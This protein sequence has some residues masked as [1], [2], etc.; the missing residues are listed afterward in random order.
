[1]KFLNVLHRPEVEWTTAAQSNIIKTKVEIHRYL[2]QSTNDLV[3]SYKNVKIIDKETAKELYE[4]FVEIAQVLYERCLARMAEFVDFDS[5]TA[6]LVA[7]CFY[8][9]VAY[10]AVHF[11]NNFN[12]L[13]SSISKYED[14]LREEKKRIN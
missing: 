6:V 7:E 3:L 5:A 2:L 9:I 13:L 1:M 11:K 8:N 10:V 12:L 4:Y 14:F